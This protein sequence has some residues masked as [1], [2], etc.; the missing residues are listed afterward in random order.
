MAK[1]KKIKT[2][3]QKAGQSVRT[4][5]NKIKIIKNALT[6]AK[7]SGKAQLEKSLEFWQSKLK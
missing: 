6:I 1:G 3:Q 5:K 2:A 4:A 7:G